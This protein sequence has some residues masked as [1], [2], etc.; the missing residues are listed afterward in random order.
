[1]SARK[2]IAFIASFAALY[3]GLIFVGLALTGAGHGSDYFGAALLAPFSAFGDGLWVLFAGLTLWVL[4]PLLVAMRRF[5]WCRFAAATILVAHY[6]G[7]LFVSLG[8]Q[9][10]YYVGQVWRATWVVVVV[11][12]GAYF[13]S[14]GFMWSLIARRH[15]GA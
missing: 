2:A 10:W 15:Y 14:Q 6:L 11:L 9:D 12:A 3:G 4:V 7:V 1:M 5:T 13:A 8:R